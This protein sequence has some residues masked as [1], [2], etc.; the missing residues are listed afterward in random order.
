MNTTSKSMKSPKNP[1]TS[2][3]NYFYHIKPLSKHRPSTPTPI[4]KQFF[5][6]SSHKDRSFHLISQ[7]APKT[8]TKCV[9]CDLG[10]NLITDYDLE[11]SSGVNSNNNISLESFSKTNPISSQKSH[12]YDSK[13][14]NIGYLDSH[15]KHPSPILHIDYEENSRLNYKSFGTNVK[16]GSYTNR[17]G[18]NI[19]NMGSPINMIGSNNVNS[20]RNNPCSQANNN[21]LGPFSNTE[22]SPSLVECET[23]ESLMNENSFHN[24]RRITGRDLSM[25]ILEEKS[26]QEYIISMETRIKKCEDEEKSILKKIEITK[27]FEEK[28]NEKRR[29][30][31]NLMK[32]I[33]NKKTYNEKKQ[34]EL[35]QKNQL[36]KRL[37]KENIHK[38]MNK[39][40][41]GK[42]QKVLQ[43][44][45]NKENLMEKANLKRELEHSEKI[46]K[47]NGV[48][49]FEK[50][51]K[52]K[53]VLNVSQREIHI[54]SNIIDQVQSEKE[55]LENLKT[56][57]QELVKQ[58]AASKAKLEDV[59]Q[60]HMIK[61]F[62][63]QQL[64]EKNPTTTDIQEKSNRGYTMASTAT[65]DEGRSASSGV[66]INTSVISLANNRF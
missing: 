7:R 13:S 37:N 15:I 6:T 39:L 21:K 3:E 64:F 41:M 16:K 52:S 46:I 20:N 44:K 45:E 14:G 42:Q 61:Y 8:P 63:L 62:K 18:L 53:K 24:S 43:I 47:V 34:D 48:L 5:S 9:T 30:I 26:L 50:K 57:A 31:E 22:R 36:E 40:H 51:L 29:D 17:I 59:R 55:K 1:P 66:H 49:N 12:K 33:N 58:E 35:K 28:I 23:E 54:K 60:L 11:P 32:D 56:K 65:F 10:R 25:I 38:N 4:S 19:T 27:K 2:F